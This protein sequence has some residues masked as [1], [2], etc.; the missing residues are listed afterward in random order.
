ML[1]RES[2]VLLWIHPFC[3]PVRA[4]PPR[5]VK[6]HLAQKVH[7]QLNMLNLPASLL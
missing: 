7:A 3:L 2:S 1:L 4:Q 6:Q 5:N